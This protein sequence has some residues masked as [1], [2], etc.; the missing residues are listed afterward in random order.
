MQFQYDEKQLFLPLNHNSRI[1]GYQVYDLTNSEI[2][3]INS[4]L[5]RHFFSTL[6]LIV[7]SIY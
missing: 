4:V 1:T 3:T 2:R 6:I 7:L 5:I